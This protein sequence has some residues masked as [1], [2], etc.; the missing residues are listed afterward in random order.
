MFYWKLQGLQR[1]QLKT[2]AEKKKK[3]NCQIYNTMP[4]IMDRWYWSSVWYVMLINVSN[5]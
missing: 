4:A 2:T 3:K 5:T 1:R